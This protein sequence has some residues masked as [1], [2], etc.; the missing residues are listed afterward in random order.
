VN[1]QILYQINRMLSGHM[2]WDYTFRRWE[3]SWVEVER[4]LEKNSREQKPKPKSKM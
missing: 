2:N 3:K 1:K 4:F